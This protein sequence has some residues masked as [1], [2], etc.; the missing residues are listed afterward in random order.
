MAVRMRDTQPPTAEVVAEV[1]GLPVAVLHR[2]EPL[3]MEL[4]LMEV[5]AGKK[6]G[7]KF[8]RR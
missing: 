3:R 7:V 4:H 5:E 8:T 1:F 6:W 2:V